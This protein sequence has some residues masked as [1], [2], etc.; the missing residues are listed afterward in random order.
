MVQQQEKKSLDTDAVP[1]TIVHS[2][3]IAD[4]SLFVVFAGHTHESILAEETA[5]CE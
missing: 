3:E 4:D 2:H 1:V 5:R